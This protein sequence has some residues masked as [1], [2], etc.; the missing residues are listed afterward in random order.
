ML[1]HKVTYIVSNSHDYVVAVFDNIDDAIHL[2]SKRHYFV[3]NKVWKNLGNEM[4]FED[5]VVYEIPMNVFPTT[6]VKLEFEFTPEDLFSEDIHKH[7]MEKQSIVERAKT[8]EDSL[9]AIEKTMCQERG[10]NWKCSLQDKEIDILV[11]FEDAMFEE[12]IYE[13]W[14]TAHLE[15]ITKRTFFPKKPKFLRGK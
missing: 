7:K 9:K 8:A 14:G 6:R 4:D 5:Y 3:K 2:C 13:P 12:T 11:L 15:T 10:P 1:E